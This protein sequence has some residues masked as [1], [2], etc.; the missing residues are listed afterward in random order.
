VNISRFAIAV[1]CSAC[2]FLVAISQTQSK[3]RSVLFTASDGVSKQTFKVR[4]SNA[5]DIKHA[6]DILAHTVNDHMGIMGTVVLGD[7]GYNSPWHF[8]LTD[9]SFFSR[10]EE[11][12]DAKLAD[13]ERFARDGKLPGSIHNVWCPWSSHLVEEVANK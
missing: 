6:R 1:A 4:L 8:H 11:N 5:A 12:C 9:P 7:G 2:I 3:A 10:V 13:I